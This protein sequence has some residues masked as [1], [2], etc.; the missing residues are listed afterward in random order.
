LIRSSLNGR[1]GYKHIEALKS[2][3]RGSPALA[4]GLFL[5]VASSALADSNHLRGK[6][7]LLATY[8]FP[9]I[10]NEIKASGNTADVVEPVPQ[11]DPVLARMF[12]NMVH[13]TFM[14]RPLEVLA[15]KETES[16]GFAIPYQTL[17]ELL[18]YFDQYLPDKSKA[19]RERF[20]DVIAE[21]RRTN[22]Q[23]LAEQMAEETT[24]ALSI[25]EQE[26]LDKAEA[27]DSERM[28]G[29]Y[30]AQVAML[31]LM[32]D[33]DFD[34]ALSIASTIGNEE[35]RRGA[36]LFLTIIASSMALEKGDT[37]RA[38][39]YSKDLPVS[40]ERAGLLIGVANSLA[41]KGKNEKAGALLMEVKDQLLNEIDDSK[42]KVRALILLA[43]VAVSTD[44]EMAFQAMKLAV[45]CDNRIGPAFEM[46][47]YDLTSGRLVAVAI[48]RFDRN[49]TFSWL[50]RVDFDRS[51][52]LA[53]LILDR[54]ASTVAEMAICRGILTKS[55]SPRPL[56]EPNIF[57]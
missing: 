19:I 7:C 26:L 51:L 47:G 8:L 55:I 39:Q 30:Y 2:L 48:S 43:D 44:P 27:A 49:Q 42:D 52:S 3:R 40:I 12:L 4:D 15:S 36:I 25:S 53:R 9:I 28:R 41:A 14:Q 46:D 11:V 13:E 24:K 37:D 50:A 18:P 1:F 35:D 22:A 16:G 23:G 34:R 6:I 5:H 33:Q 31:A 20:A 32:R 29:K 45:E 56:A 17:S 54:E 38:Y 10:Q 57:R 21:I